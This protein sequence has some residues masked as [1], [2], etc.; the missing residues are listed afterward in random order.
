MHFLIDYENVHS[1]G[2]TG[3]ELLT[4]Q[5]TVVLFYSDSNDKVEQGA[6]NRIIQS[7]CKIELRKLKTKGKNAL[8]FYIATYVGELLLLAQLNHELCA[9]DKSVHP[10][11][12]NLEI[13]PVFLRFRSLSGTISHPAS[14]FTIQL[15]EQ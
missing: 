8:D 7:G 12:L 5:D 3:A 11:S 2:L 6:M 14:E 15:G 13:P 4:D 9:G 10:A 1:A